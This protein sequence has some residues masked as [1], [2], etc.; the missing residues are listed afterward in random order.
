MNTTKQKE[1]NKKKAL[2]ALKA[3]CLYYTGKPPV[4]G[5][6]VKILVTFLFLCLMPF[7]RAQ[8]PSDTLYVVASDMMRPAYYGPGNFIENDLCYTRR[9]AHR[10][11]QVV[12]LTK[13]QGKKVYL[14]R[15]Y[16]KGSSV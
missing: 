15:P 7:A 9:N 16:R 1:Q 6:P 2:A 4:K 5:K 10:L 11:C 3:L 12:G 13:L 8:C 14:V